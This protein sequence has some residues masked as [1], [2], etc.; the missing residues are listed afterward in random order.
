MSTLYWV[1]HAH[2]EWTPDENRPLSAQGS[3]DANRVADLLCAYPI[4]AIYSSPAQRACQTVTPLAG[5]LGLAIRLEPNLHERRLGG[6]V[7]EDFFKAVE[8]TWRDPTFAYPGGESSTMAQKRGI[9]VVQRLLEKH[10]AEHIVIS[11][12]G[13]LMAL[14]LQTF[15]PSVDFL[16]W[17]SLAMPDV[18]KLNISQSG[19]GL[20]QRLWQEVDA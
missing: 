8:V 2:T 13:N 16:F 4:S 15:D 9:A 19:K 18:Y 17:K 7:F 14:V 3:E 10:L 12:H 1:R 11:T 20:M 5:R 6:G